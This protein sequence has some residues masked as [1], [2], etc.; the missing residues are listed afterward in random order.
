VEAMTFLVR[1]VAISLLF[2]SS[3]TFSQEWSP[4]QLDVWASVEKLVEDFY[5]GNVEDLDRHPD[6]VFWNAQNPA[7]GDKQAAALQDEK[8]FRSG[9]KFYDATIT[10]LTINVHGDFATVNAYIQV[11]QLLPGEESRTLISARFH[12]DWTKEDDTW[13]NTS[14]FLYREE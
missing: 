4:E 3:A 12:S 14:N 6:F 13:F 10:P 1:I 7:P 2:D 5:A 9:V 8:L 11:F